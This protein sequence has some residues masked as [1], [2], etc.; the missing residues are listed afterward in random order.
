MPFHA[1]SPQ[2]RDRV[3]KELM[4][5]HAADKAAEAFVWQRLGGICLGHSRGQH[6]GNHPLGE[7]MQRLEVKNAQDEILA[8]GAD[9][10]LQAVHRLLGCSDQSPCALWV[11]RAQERRHHIAFGL[12][13]RWA[14]GE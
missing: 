5:C 11:H 2:E 1:T 13:R 3:G 7:Q 12:E 9:Q 4:A 6:S 8:T 14:I 10:R